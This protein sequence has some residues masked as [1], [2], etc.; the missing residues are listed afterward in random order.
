MNDVSG[1]M[2]K[3]CQEIKR[4]ALRSTR[5]SSKEKLCPVP[6]ERLFLQNRFKFTTY[7]RRRFKALPIK[8]I[9]DG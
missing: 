4:F 2:E 1:K 7:L 8:Q 6:M 9:K 3:L 5:D